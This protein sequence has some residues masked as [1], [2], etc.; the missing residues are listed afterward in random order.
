M[1]DKPGNGSPQ[2]SRH[3]D[4]DRMVPVSIIEPIGMRYGKDFVVLFGFERIGCKMYRTTWGRTAEDKLL[5]AEL[6][7]NFMQNLGFALDKVLEDFRTVPAG[8]YKAL[9]DECRQTLQEL[10]SPPVSRVQMD[11]IRDL[12]KRLEAVGQ[13]QEDSSTEGEAGGE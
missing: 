11:K 3:P 10:N 4:A 6:T 13:T 8:M 2:P 1:S 9:L 7:D 12:I 5:A